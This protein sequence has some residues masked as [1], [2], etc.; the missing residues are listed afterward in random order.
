MVH[1]MP[2]L[3]DISLDEVIGELEN[4]VKMRHRVFG[5]Q[6][7][8]QR[9]MQSTKDRRIARIEKAIEWLRERTP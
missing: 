7:A 2:E 1:V 3:F 6:V 8:E 9:M 4:E 5:R